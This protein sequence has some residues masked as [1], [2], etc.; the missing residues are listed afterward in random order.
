MPLLLRASVF[1]VGT[2]G[3]L[4]HPNVL[5]MIVILLVA[6]AVALLLHT[7]FGAIT[8]ALLAP[9]PAILVSHL[10]VEPAL[11]GYAVDARVVLHALTAYM[12][13]SCLAVLSVGFL[14]SLSLLDLIC[15]CRTL[16]LGSWLIVGWSVVTNSIEIARYQ[17]FG[18]RVE[19]AFRQPGNARTRRR[20][21]NRALVTAGLFITID[22]LVR[23]STIA[24]VCRGRGVE[25]RVVP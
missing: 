16:R 3:V 22:M 9:L 14:L 6:L 10:L 19:W 8:L 4:T 25:L 23:A 13:L 15:V 2:L 1:L 24:A 21:T 11:A 5:T 17:F 7:N 20:L 12:R 18:A